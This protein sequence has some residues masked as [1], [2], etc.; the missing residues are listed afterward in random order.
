[1]KT[2]KNPGAGR[3]FLAAVLALVSVLAVF[4]ADRELIFTASTPVVIPKDVSTAQSPTDGSL[5]IPGSAVA[6]AS[7]PV[8][9]AASA[10]APATASATASRHYVVASG[11]S[12]WKI[13]TRFFGDGSRYMEIVQANKDRYPSLLKNPNLIYPGWELI[14]PGVSPD[15]VTTGTQASPGSSTSTSSGPVGTPPRGISPRAPTGGAVTT[16]SPQFMGWWGEAIQAAQSWNFPAVTN[17]YGQ[18]VTREDFMRSILNIE[19]NGIHQRSNGTL[20]TSS[21]GAQGFMQLMPGTAAGL[22]VD[23]TDPRQNLIGGA[24][25]LTTCFKGPNVSNTGDSPADRMIKA[26][27]GYN[28]GPYASDLKNKT[29]EQYVQTSRVTE[30]VQYGIYM[31]MSM[32]IELSSTDKSW[33]MRKRNISS[34]AVDRMADDYYARSKGLVS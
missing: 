26:A 19:S 17:K 7:P 2:R 15:V 11:D 18:T 10:S 25:Y 6:I 13:A 23:G 20:V 24:R 3:L 14:I 28:R 9:A 29:W 30:N 21:C 27:C 1:M 22:H 12:L 4:G 16:K 34:E 32:G 31:K 33:M 5:V 8:I